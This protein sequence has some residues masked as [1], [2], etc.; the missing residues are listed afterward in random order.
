MGSSLNKTLEIGLKEWAIVCSAL[1][2]GEQIV[3]LRK[4]GIYESAGEF[5]VEH[6]QFLLFPTYLHQKQSMLKPPQAAA[7]VQRATEPEVVEL[8]AAGVVTD[9]I[10]LNSRSQMDAIEDQHIWTA[11]LIDMRFNYRPENPLYLMLVRAW[12]LPAV[13]KLAN[14]ME[15][16]GCKSWVP[17]GQAI[18]TEGATPAMSDE[19]YAAK[20]EMIRQRLSSAK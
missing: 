15:F 10:R 20:Q 3:L 18:S 19:A 17:L 12:K 11:P 6:R 16:A 7:M 9:I 13:V 14:T 4:G 8:A 5:E 1:A 2:G